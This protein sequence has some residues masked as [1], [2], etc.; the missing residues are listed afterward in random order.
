VNLQAC[1]HGKQGRRTSSALRRLLAAINADAAFLAAQDDPPAMERL[2]EETLRTGDPARIAPL[3][4]ALYY[5][6]DVAAQ[7]ARALVLFACAHTFGDNT[8]EAAASVL[9]ARQ[10]DDTAAQAQLPG[11]FALAATLPKLATLAPYFTEP[12]PTTTDGGQPQ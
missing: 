11:L 12:L 3:A 9:S 2:I 1:G 6:T 10:T 7:Q 5:A 8:D 4:Q